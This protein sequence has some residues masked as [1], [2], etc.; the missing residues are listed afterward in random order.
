MIPK[1][2]SNV[3]SVSNQSCAKS[4]GNHWRM[5][6]AWKC[7]CNSKNICQRAIYESLLLRNIKTKNKLSV[8]VID[9]IFFSFYNQGDKFKKQTVTKQKRSKIY[10]LHGRFTLVMTIEYFIVH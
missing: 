1:Y 9:A 10:Y 5:T 2:T 4:A 7:N 6:I 8:R 3:H